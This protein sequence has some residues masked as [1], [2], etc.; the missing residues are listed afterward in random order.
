MA[1]TLTQTM[2]VVIQNKFED[3]KW[4]QEAQYTT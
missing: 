1:S 4:A 2:P 3:S